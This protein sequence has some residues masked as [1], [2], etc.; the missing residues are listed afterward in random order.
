[1]IMRGESE[2][3]FSKH[4]G[5]QG[6]QQVY[7]IW[8][9]IRDETSWRIRNE[10]IYG[11]TEEEKLLKLTEALGTQ[12]RLR[13]A[14]DTHQQVQ[15]TDKHDLFLLPVEVQIKMHDALKQKRLNQKKQPLL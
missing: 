12:I 13:Y 8:Q 5:A 1:M 6:R 9:R 15:E 2:T 4:S 3:L 14:T 7:G 10:E 11:K